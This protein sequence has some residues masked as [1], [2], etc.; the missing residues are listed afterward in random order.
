[1]QFA[2]AAQAELRTDLERLQA[3]RDQLFGEVNNLGSWLQGE[4][5]R[6]RRALIDVA[7]R[8]ENVREKGDAPPVR[9]RTCRRRPARSSKP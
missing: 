7:D 8:I 9:P 4:R 3:A 1:M 2:E 6:I 5:S